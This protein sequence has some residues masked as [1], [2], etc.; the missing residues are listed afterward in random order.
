MHSVTDVLGAGRPCGDERGQ[1]GRVR[2]SKC[3]DAHSMRSRGRCCDVG[4]WSKWNS[5]GLHGEERKVEQPER[6]P[7]FRGDRDA[8][9]RCS[10]RR[11]GGASRAGVA[12]ARAVAEGVDLSAR[13]GHGAA[14]DGRSYLPAAGRRGRDSH[15][16]RAIPRRGRRHSRQGSSSDYRST[17]AASACRNV[18]SANARSSS[19][20]VHWRCPDRHH[21]M[22]ARWTVVNTERTRKFRGQWWAHKGSNLGPLPCEGNALPLSYAPG[23]WWLP[24]VGP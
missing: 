19:P 12:E 2:R 8:R 5:F 22:A 20:S 16:D 7:L 21:A 4:L 11:S 13:S 9:A 10:R 6:G 17:S 3:L 15:G 14:V 1:N 18:N 23:S 24:A